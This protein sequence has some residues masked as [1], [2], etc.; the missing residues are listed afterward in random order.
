MLVIRNYFGT[1]TPAS[2]PALSIQTGDIIELICADLHSPWWQVRLLLHLFIAS[3]S[4]TE[5]W[6]CGIEV[7]NVGPAMLYPHPKFDNGL[8]ITPL[9]VQTGIAC[10]VPVL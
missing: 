5:K 8:R 7:S 3:F 1:P 4:R 2:G 10:S 6:I 9:S